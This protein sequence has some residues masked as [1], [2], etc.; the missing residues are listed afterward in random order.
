[1]NETPYNEGGCLRAIFVML[2]VIG[3]LILLASLFKSFF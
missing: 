3:M 1:M 2:F